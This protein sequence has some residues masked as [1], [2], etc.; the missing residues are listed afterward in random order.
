LVKSNA[1]AVANAG[2]KIEEKLVVAIILANL[3]PDFTD[4]ATTLDTLEK[5]TMEK[6]TTVLLNPGKKRQSRY[7]AIVNTK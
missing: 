3:P 5:G 6:D 1:P 4:V 2:V 7:G